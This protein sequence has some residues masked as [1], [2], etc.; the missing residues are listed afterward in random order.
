MERINIEESVENALLAIPVP[1][2]VDGTE[3]YLYPKTLG[4]VFLLNRLRKQLEISEKFAHTD[5]YAE[6]LRVCSEKKD[7]VL[8]MIAY[9]TMPTKQDVFD[10]SGIKDRMSFLKKHLSNEDL[11]TLFLSIIAEDDVPMLEKHFDI[12]KD[13]ENKRKIAKVKESKSSVTFGGHSIWGI[14]ID[15]ACQRYGWTVEYVVWSVSYTNLM[16]MY[17]DRIESIY[18]SEEERKKLGYGFDDEIIN[19]DDP[20]NQE[21]IRKIL[22]E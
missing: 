14:L 6:S 11:A 12:S 17:H 13:D 1:F 10:E 9:C 16:M 3:L 21:L 4:K 7:I 18:L 22:E 15:F 19:A 20:K 5:P 8:R 2:S